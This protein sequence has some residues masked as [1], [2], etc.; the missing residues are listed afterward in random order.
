VSAEVGRGGTPAGG[1]AVGFA[2]VD[3]KGKVAASSYQRVRTTR[4]ATTDG[5]VSYLGSTS[6]DPGR[7]V[8]TLAAIDSRGRRGSVEHPVRAS[9]TTIGPFEVSDLVVAPPPR[10]AGTSL[11]PGVETAIDAGRSWPSWSCTPRRPA[12]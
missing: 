7:Y 11:R 5:P 10:Q 12:R 4:P 3:D 2:L 9:L 6:V 1:L 8:L